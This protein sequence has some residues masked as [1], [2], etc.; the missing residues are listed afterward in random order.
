M[1]KAKRSPSS[2]QR[3]PT[4]ADSLPAG[5]QDAEVPKPRK[6]ATKVDPK[7]DRR[8]E[9]GDYQPYARFA[10]MQ[11]RKAWKSQDDCDRPYDAFWFCEPCKGPDGETLFLEGSGKLDRGVLRPPRRCLG[12]EDLPASDSRSAWSRPSGKV[13]NALLFRDYVTLACASKRSVRE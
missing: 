6:K 5:S 1:P 3:D 7:Q 8:L 2:S 9:I 11:I 10:Q 12:A 4:E 13:E